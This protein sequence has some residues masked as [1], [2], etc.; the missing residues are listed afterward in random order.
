MCSHLFLVGLFEL[1]KLKKH[2]FFFLRIEP[3]AAGADQLPTWMLLP[4]TWGE[5]SAEGLKIK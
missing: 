5:S 1:L 2:I 3:E 4:H